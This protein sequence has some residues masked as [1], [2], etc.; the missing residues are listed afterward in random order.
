MKA[1][2]TSLCLLLVV[3]CAH[4]QNK[5]IVEY[6]GTCNNVLTLAQEEMLEVQDKLFD[7]KDLERLEGIA[8]EFG[9]DHKCLS[10]NEV[11]FVTTVYLVFINENGRKICATNDW[12]VYSKMERGEILYEIVESYNEAVDFC[13]GENVST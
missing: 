9:V 13:K 5:G 12:L 11:L 1:L 3:G 7:E 6:V 2:L 10:K 8:L 4:T